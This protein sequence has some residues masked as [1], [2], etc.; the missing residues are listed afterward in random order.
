MR[1][2]PKIIL[3]LRLEFF[4]CIFIVALLF[5]VKKISLD[6]CFYSIYLSIYLL[7]I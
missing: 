3:Y 6:I 2:Q 5:L 1:L 7:L 4:A